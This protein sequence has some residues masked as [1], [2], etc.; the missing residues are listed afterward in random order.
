MTYSS[1]IN[2]T[3]PPTDSNLTS[4]PIRSNFQA[5]SNDINFIYGLINAITTGGTVIGP[6]LTTNTAIVRWN[7]TGGT[8]IEDSGVLIDN[9]NNITG[10]TWQGA[11]VGVP[12]GGT[13]QTTFTNGQLLIGNTVGNTLAKSTLTAGAN[14]SITNGNGTITIAATGGSGSVTSIDVSG[15]TTGLTTSGGPVTTSGTIT[16]AGTLNVTNGGTGTTTSTGSGSVVLG[17]SPTITTPTI[18]LKVTDK[19]ANY[20]LTAAD[21]GQIFTNNGAAG[22]ITFSLPAAAAGLNYTVLADAAHIVILAADAGH[23]IRNGGSETA[24][25][26][27][28]TSDGTEG[29]ML[30]VFCSNTLQ[31]YVRHITGAWTVN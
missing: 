2:V 27:N 7:G 3:Q 19:V 4:A 17:T 18:K 31:W 29:P 8:F 24:A 28:F 25:S 26:G 1:T 5:A 15:G 14:I 21:S 12:Y 6:G 13:G 30:E 9:S 22:T 20:T 11:T 10:G 23:T 16:I